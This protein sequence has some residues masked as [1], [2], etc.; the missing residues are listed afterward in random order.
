M[1]GAAIQDRPELSAIEQLRQRVADEARLAERHERLAMEA[2]QRRRD[3][4][5]E[6]AELGGNVGTE[7]E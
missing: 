2:W 7:S 5:Q 1:P 3:Y 4:E 6:L